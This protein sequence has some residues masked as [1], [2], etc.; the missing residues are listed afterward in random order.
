MSDQKQRDAERGAALAPLNA[1]QRRDLVILA[2]NTFDKL[3]HAG[4]IPESVK[5]N[6]WRHQQCLMAVERPGLTACRQ[7][8]YLPMQAHFLGL[9]GADQLAAMAKLRAMT[10]PRR[11]AKAVLEQAKAAARDVIER[12]DD[13]VA[14]IAR[15]RFKGLSIDDLTA[16]QIWGL[17]FDIRRSAQKR[18]KKGTGK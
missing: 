17:V 16:K 18:R 12:P 10:E 11:Q 7:E 8:D 5:F 13:Y 1:E 6:D 4:G 14:A 9:I 3:R 2:R 15:C